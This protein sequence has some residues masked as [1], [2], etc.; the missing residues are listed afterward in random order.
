MPKKLSIVIPVFNESAYIVRCLENVEQVEIPNWAK[1]IVIIND[2][3]SDNSLQLIKQ[4]ASQKNNIKIVTSQ[5]KQGKGA[6][7]KKGIALATGEIV[8]I[9]DADLEY[10]PEDFKPILRQFENKNIEV[11][12][13]SRILGAKI[14]HNYS[15]SI[16]FLVG[17]IVLTKLINL[18]FSTN[19][20]DQ[21]TCYK[22]WRNHL[23]K[24]LLKYCRKPGFEFEVEMTAFFSKKGDIKEVPI[25]YYPRT[26]NHG[27]KIRLTDFFRSIATAFR[28]KFSNN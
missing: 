1:E 8:I 14:Y 6:A 9:Q 11:V 7:L 25:H 28:C 16:F 12:Y 19:L 20:T 21:P 4:F 17:G 10:D 27:K 22:S 26:I 5:K 18:L 2:G 23:S 15:A 13:G 24:E 3:S